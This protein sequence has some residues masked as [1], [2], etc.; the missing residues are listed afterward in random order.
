MSLPMPRQTTQHA[1]RYEPQLPTFQAG[2]DMDNFLNRF[3]HLPQTWRWP[4]EEWSCRL[5]PLLTG[6]A[7]EAYLAMD[8][9]E[10][11]DY[12]SCGKHY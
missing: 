2:E 11:D 4:S 7:L 12:Q 1:P 5:V 10:A 8:E 3:E 9:E 6:Q